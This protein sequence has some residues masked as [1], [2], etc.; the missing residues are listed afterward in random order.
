ML[1]FFRNQFCSHETESENAQCPT[2][3]IVQRNRK[4]YVR[5]CA[6][7]PHWV[8]VLVAS[9][10]CILP[11]S[12]SPHPRCVVAEQPYSPFRVCIYR[13][14]S[15]FRDPREIPRGEF[16]TTLVSKTRSSRRTFVQNSRARFRRREPR[17][18]FA[19]MQ[20]FLPPCP[21]VIYPTMTDVR[22]PSSM[23][24]PIFSFSKLMLQCHSIFR[25]LATKEK[26]SSV[27]ARIALPEDAM[28]Y[29][30]SSLVARRLRRCLFLRNDAISRTTVDEDVVK[31]K[32]MERRT[33]FLSK[34]MITK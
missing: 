29:F 28:Q 32:A 16:L 27:L 21:V 34:K 14:R 7:L 6:S 23:N 26:W 19:R 11:S 1:F 22:S 5:N 20:R 2:N 12:L 24:A 15:H 18:A 31:K 13:S 9:P 3:T 25:L 17:G 8:E 33:E 30:L 4:Q 10:R